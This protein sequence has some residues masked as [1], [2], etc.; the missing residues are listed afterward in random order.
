MLK[1]SVKPPWVI[2]LAKNCLVHVGESPDYLNRHA[3]CRDNSR[4]AIYL[5][6]SI[7]FPNLHKYEH[8]SPFITLQLVFVLPEG[9]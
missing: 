8:F 1:Q 5:Y 2:I 6:S 3:L 4:H 7:C 9:G